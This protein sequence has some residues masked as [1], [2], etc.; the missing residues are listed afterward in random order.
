MSVRALVVEVY[1]AKRLAQFVDQFDR[2]G[3]EIV[4]EIERVLDLVGDAGGQLAERSELLGLHQAVLRSAQILQRFRQLARALLFGFEQ[5][6]IL[7]RDH[8]LVGEMSVTSSI[9]LSVKGRTTLR[10]STITPIGSLSRIS[11]TP[12]IVRKPPRLMT[13]PIMRSPGRGQN[14]AISGLAVR[15]AMVRPI[16]RLAARRDGVAVS[17]HALYSGRMAVTCG[18]RGSLGLPFAKNRC[19]IR[20]AQARCRFDQR[21]QHRLQIEGRTADDLEHVRGRGLLLQRLPQFVEQPRVLDGDD[22]LGGEVL[23]QRDLLVGERPHLLAIDIEIAD[24][25]AVLEH[26]NEEDSSCTRTLDHVNCGRIA[27]FVRRVRRVVDDVDQLLRRRY[28]SDCRLWARI[29]YGSRWRYSAKAGGGLY[30]AT[31]RNLPSS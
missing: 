21:I 30:M 31:L 19:Q 20:F 17:I 2:D 13:R 5:P 15:A 12:S 16:Q 9:C 23:H 6:H 11:G 14:V 26:R 28:A 7:D 25:F 18:Q 10:Q 27:L 29:D 1:A 4:D 24:V 22:G 3:R 8:R